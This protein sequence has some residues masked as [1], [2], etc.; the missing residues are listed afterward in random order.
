M[1]ASDVSDTLNEAVSITGLNRIK[2]KHKLRLLSDNGPS[3]IS[4]ELADYLEDKGMTHTRGRPYHP[5]T[6]SKIEPWL[7]TM[8]SQI[9]LNNYYLPGG[10]RN[11]FSASSLTTTTSVTMNP[12]II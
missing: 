2:V 3:Y 8:K 12:W 11:I 9:Q 5:Q 7:R 4:G 1:S 6:Q 10:Y